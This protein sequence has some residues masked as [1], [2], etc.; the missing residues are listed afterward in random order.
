MKF[1][2]YCGSFIYIFGIFRY[3]LK[4]WIQKGKKA[5][6]YL[7]ADYQE[8]IAGV[9]KHLR[10]E[11]PNEHHVYVSFMKYFQFAE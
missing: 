7:I 10:R 5:D 1:K 6:D 9:I 11:T 4:Q 2:S 8:A 3:L